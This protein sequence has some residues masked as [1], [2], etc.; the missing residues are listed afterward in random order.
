MGEPLENKGEKW[1]CITN[2]EHPEHVKAQNFSYKNLQEKS[3]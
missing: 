1:L 3:K 2:K